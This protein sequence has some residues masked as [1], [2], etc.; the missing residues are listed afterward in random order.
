MKKPQGI[1]NRWPGISRI[2]EFS[3]NHRH[4][5][6]LL[7]SSR[8]QEAPRT[9]LRTLTT[10]IRRTAMIINKLWKMKGLLCLSKGPNAGH[11]YALWNF[12]RANLPWIEKTP[13]TSPSSPRWKMLHETSPWE[14]A[15]P[16]GSR[17]SHPSRKWAIHQFCSRRTRSTLW[18]PP[19]MRKLTAEIWLVLDRPL[20]A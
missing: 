18:A 15:R 5:L 6:S 1:R 20:P 8:R 4:L 11:L 7:F 16:R 14:W 12:K 17:I 13:M 10:T 2:N 19:K 9:T 3:I